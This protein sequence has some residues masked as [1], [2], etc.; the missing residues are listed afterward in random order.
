MRITRIIPL[1]ALML[2]LA[3]C[4]DDDTAV[5][6]APADTGVPITAPAYQAFREQPTACG[7]ERPAPAV[8]MQFPSAGD[9]AVTGTVTVVLHTSC[10]DVILELDADATPETVESFVFLARSGYFDG[11]VSHRIIPGYIVQAGDPTA[12]GSGNPGYLIPDELPPADFFYTR[13]V[14]AMAN[15]GVANSAGSQFF[16]MLGDAALPPTYAVFGR[17]VEGFDVLDTLAALPMGPNPNDPTPSRPL[18]TVYLEWVEVV[19]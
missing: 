3:A 18:E 5:T 7:A 14:I 6:E 16:I 15:A 9:A 8:E 19:G 17:V 11:T 10:G 1:L 12:S 13:G 2:L 4:G